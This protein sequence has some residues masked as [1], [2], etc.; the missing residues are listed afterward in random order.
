MGNILAVTEPSSWALMG[1]G[2]VILFIR[3]KHHLSLSIRR[4]D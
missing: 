3:G 2:L 4:R 1:L